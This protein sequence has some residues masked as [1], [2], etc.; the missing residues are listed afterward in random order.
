MKPFWTAP[1]QPNDGGTRGL[2]FTF[3]GGKCAVT[4]YKGQETEVTVPPRRRKHPVTDVGDGAFLGDKIRRVIL[5][6]GVE[7]IGDYAF[8]C[9][10]WL[11]EIHLPSGLTRIGKNAFLDCCR[12]AHLTVPDSVTE[13]GYAALD[14]TAYMSNP[15]HWENDAFFIGGH[16]LAVRTSVQGDYTVGERFRYISEYAFE[17]C[18][19]IRTIRLPAGLLRIG[20]WAFFRCRGLSEITLP[21]GVLSVGRFAFSECEGMEEI[22]LPKS[23]TTLGDYVFS[24]CPRLTAVHYAGTRAEWAQMEKGME[25]FKGTPDSLFIHCADGDLQKS[26][27]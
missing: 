4:D 15:A 12:L 9:C 17:E 8:E 2:K 27:A 21:E 3:K 6:E 24:D 7:R 23:L 14:G 10:Y 13:I 5:P 11:T 18:E 19:G 16:V 26:E 1:Q 20:R 25:C 22:T